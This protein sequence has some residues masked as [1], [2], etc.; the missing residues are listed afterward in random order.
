MDLTFQTV[1]MVCARAVFNPEK[2][3]LDL[4]EVTFFRPFALVY[5]GMFL[6]YQNSCGTV[7]GVI[8]PDNPQARSYLSGQNFWERF[9]FPAE[10]IDREKLHGFTSSSSLND[11][12]DIEK[13]NTIAEDVLKEVIH[14]IQRN[15]LRVQGAEVAGMVCELVD[16][17][18][19]HSKQTLAV[20]HMQYYPKLKEVVLAIGD[21]GIGIRAS[22]CTNPKY[23]YLEKLP[24]HEAALL[25]FEPLVSCKPEGGTGLTEV[26]DGVKRLGGHL[27]LAT[28]DEYVTMYQETITYGSMAYDLNGVQI[29]LS[30]PVEA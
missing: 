26:R 21:C 17:F 10:A 22:L 13:T 6:R 24:H 15:R 30:F 19:R 29:E 18:A 14:V 23:T 7:C 8:V 5:L 3:V 27:V 4:S 12:I 16:N 1:D 9:K 28:G 11:I 25:A 20:F 2:P